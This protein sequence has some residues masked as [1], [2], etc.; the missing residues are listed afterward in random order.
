MRMRENMTARARLTNNSVASLDEQSELLG[1]VLG[2]A[3]MEK[4]SDRDKKKLIKK[5]KELEL[6]RLLEL[7]KKKAGMPGVSAQSTKT[8]TPV[9]ASISS[10]SASAGSASVA[11][12]GLLGQVP[13]T[14]DAT[15][16][17]L[18]ESVFNT[19]LNWAQMQAQARAQAQAQAY[20]MSGFGNFVPNFTFGLGAPPQWGYDW[21]HMNDPTMAHSVSDC[22]TKSDVIVVQPISQELDQDSPQVKSTGMLADFFKEQLTQVKESDKVAPK[23]DDELALVLNRIL[24]DAI[25]PTDMDKL[26]KSYPRI[27]N[28]EYMKVPKL[29]TEIYEAIDQKVRNFDQSLQSIQKAIMAA[30]SAIAPTLRL[31]YTRQESDDELNGLGR[32]LGESVKLLGYAANNLSSKRRELIKPCL[33]PKYAKTLSKGNDSNPE[34]LFGGDLMTTTKRC[35]VSQKIGEKVLKRKPEAQGKLPPNKKF[36]GRK[37][38]PMLR[39]FNPY[40]MQGFRFPSPQ[41]PN[42]QM[43]PQQNMGFPMGFQRSFAHVSLT[44]TRAINRHFQRNRTMES[45]G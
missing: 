33:A 38:P 1:D 11:T 34:W 9:T 23:L 26:S 40:Q 6:A 7:E 13:V 18:E 30:V 24:A 19:G 25:Y 32:Q 16:S 28:V 12:G 5:K 31:V 39:G 4:L 43:Y 8:S 44:K 3:D 36:R 22:E 35:E 15:D 27:E 45:K 41:M 20:Q 42:F 10:A 17:D 29:D 37:G 21:S 2:Q 14:E